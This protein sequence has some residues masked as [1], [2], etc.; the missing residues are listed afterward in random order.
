M[1]L[2]NLFMMA[3]LFIAVHATAQQMPQLPVD[4]DVRIGKLDNGL[5]YY[6]RYNNWPENRAEF[7]IAQKVGSIQEN[8]DQRG[9]A[10]FLE[11]MCFNGTK[12][13][14]GNGVMRYCESIG[15]QFGRDLNAYTSIDRTVYNISNVPTARTG[16]QDS[17]LLIL[18][19]WADG[20]LLEPEEI[21]KERGVIH[22]EWRLRSDA[23]G[24]MIERCLPKLYPGSKYGMRYPIGLMEV[25]DNFKPQTLRDYYEKWYHPSNQAII[26]VGD[27]DVDRIEG[28]IK[29]LFGSIKEPENPAP[30]VDEQ[31]PDNDTPIFIVEK[32]KEQK[33][34]GVEMM[35]KHDAFPDSLKNT[36]AFILNNYIRGRAMGMLNDR[37]DEM[38]QQPDCPFVNAGISD[39]RYIFSKTKEALDIDVTPKDGKL[40]AAIAAAFK[41]A[42]R[43]AEFGFTATEFQRSKSDYESYLDKSYSNK[44][45]RTNAQFVN[46]YVNNF[47]DNEPIP[48]FDDYYALMKQIMPAIPLDVVNEYMKE[49]VPPSDT[50]VVVL[51]MLNEKEGNVYPTEAS[52][53]KAIDGARAEQLTAYVD[54]VKDEPLM[55]SLPKR[56]A[57]LE[58]KNSDKFDYQTLLLSNG[59]KVVLKKTDYKKDQVI[60]SGSSEGGS[61]LYTEKDIPNLNM[62]NRVIDASG[63]GNFSNTELKKALAG[64]IAG[65]T[66]SLSERK[67]TVSGNSTPKDMETLFQLIYLYLTNKVQK[68]QKSFDNLMNS[69]ELQLKNKALDPMAVYQDSLSNTLYAHNKWSKPMEM[70][71]LKK[72]N[73]DRI[74]QIAKERFSYAD[75]YTFT[76]IGNFEEDSIRPLIETYLASLPVSGN[77][78]KSRKMV[79]IVKGNVKNSF[80]RKMETPQAISV[81]V[82]TNKDM[83]HNLKN[84]VQADMAGQ[85]LSMIYLKKIREDASAAYSCGA[86]GAFQRD[87]FDKMA[88][89]QVY[90]PMKPEMA[91]VA[92]KIM[93]EEVP[94]L[95]KSC[96][97][98]MLTKVKEYM[99]KNVDDAA[100]SNS[101]WSNV[102]T[103]YRKFGVDLHTDYKKVVE[104]QTPESICQ[105]M[106]E[107]LKAGNKVEVTMLPQE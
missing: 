107:F 71:D 3:F 6:I 78:K 27:V 46:E 72:V 77:V 60:L 19:D 30:V 17:C 73:Y 93:S 36:V 80:K 74:L 85:I 15:V 101:Y 64:K 16:A 21:D 31:V 103:N 26:V 13:F 62:F 104:A 48:S 61:S 40:E 92:L 105:F 47:L 41:E 11:H 88:L 8:D 7:Y 59:V 68:D 43:A 1:R 53:K 81:M 10:H 38:A 100:K 96:D 56:G 44:D 42:R 90:C 29:E 2:K 98:D 33:T 54:N 67:Q 18:H 52:L 86:Q 65:A 84:E 49:L 51:T 91:D 57:I 70:K 45:K 12:N 83:E 89:L 58:T 50:N 28:K 76:I 102:I 75:D 97:A 66:I 9:L 87:E 69:M 39:G 82:W 25:V 24:R 106:Q 4:K 63:L 5:T 22:E 32:D 37:L 94:A 35:I 95:A 34:N 99:L 14:P 20:L 79:D 55:T 23:Q